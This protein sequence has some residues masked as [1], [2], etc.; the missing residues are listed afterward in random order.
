MPVLLRR[1]AFAVLLGGI[2]TGASARLAAAEE[3]GPPLV[4]EAKIP[5]KEVSGRIDHLAVDLARRRLFVAELGNNTVDVI[6]LDKQQPIQR[7]GGLKEP[8]GVAYVAATDSVVVA[9]AKDG[10]VA[11]FGGGDLAPLGTIDLG[12]DADN[13]RLLGQT[14][15]I[16]VGFGRAASPSSTRAPV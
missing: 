14:G 4:L 8:Q 7:L 9:N 15:R 10:S 3:A 12:D 11:F 2:W 1:L 13:I 16:V 6:D 5:L